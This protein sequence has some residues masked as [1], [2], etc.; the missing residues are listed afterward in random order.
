[1]EELDLLRHQVAELAER[2]DFAERVL[3]SVRTEKD[4]VRPGL[5]S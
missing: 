4:A 2:V 5:P 3:A 1:M